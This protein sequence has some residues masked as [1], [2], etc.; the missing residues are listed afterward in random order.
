MSRPR[1]AASWPPP[2]AYASLILGDLDSAADQV[3]DPDV[4]ARTRRLRARPARPGCGARPRCSCGLRARSGPARAL[5]AAPGRP[6]WG[7]S[8]VTSCGWKRPGSLPRARRWDGQHGGGDGQRRRPLRRDP[9]G[10]GVR[11]GHGDSSGG[12][13]LAVDRINGRTAPG[14]HVPRWGAR[15]WDGPGRTRPRGDARM[16]IATPEVY[17]AMLDA[18]KENASRPP[19]STCRR[20]RP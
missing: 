16:P 13:W 5:V 9:R 19:P 18:A 15:V 3:G 12:W 1:A 14:S 2:A 17:A 20:R 6:G 10:F 11:T 7:C 4:E 8:T